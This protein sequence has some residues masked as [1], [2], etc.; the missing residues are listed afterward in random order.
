MAA[1]PERIRRARTLSRISQLALANIVGVQ[2]S[3]VAQW[4]RKDGSHPS[5][6]HLIAIALATGVCLE[7][8]GTGRGPVKPGEDAWTPAMRTD[9]Y[10]QDDI[11][12]ECLDS[13]RKIPFQIRKQLVG[14]ISL[15]SRNY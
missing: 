4:E 10:A 8:L 2:R 11:E 14:I 5:M 15:V 1:L 7:W 3:A 6:H 13:L 12:S 9:D